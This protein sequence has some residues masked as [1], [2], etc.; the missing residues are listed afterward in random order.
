[1]VD[2]AARDLPGR[3]T[4]FA[5]LVQGLPRTARLDAPG[6]LHHLMIRGMERRKI[7]RIAA[8]PLIGR[9]P[10]NLRELVRYIEESCSPD[11]SGSTLRSDKL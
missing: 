4:L 10:P 11:R 3:G 8:N 6:V 2:Q 7:F 1:M 9:K 5:N